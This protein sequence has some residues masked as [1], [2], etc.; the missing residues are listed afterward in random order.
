MKRLFY[1]LMMVCILLTSCSFQE[2]PEEKGLPPVTVSG[3]S[4]HV[5][6]KLKNHMDYAFANSTGI[7]R[8]KMDHGIIQYNRDGQV[9]DEAE[10][11]DVCS[12]SSKP[13]YEPY[14]YYVDD[15]A[16]YFYLWDEDNSWW[17]YRIPFTKNKKGQVVLDYANRE[18]LYDTSNMEAFAVAGNYFVGLT[19]HQVMVTMNIA[20]KRDKKFK[21]LPYLSENCEDWMVLK[22]GEDW[23]LWWG[24]GLVLQKVPSN[25]IIRLETKRNVW[26][27]ATYEMG[28]KDIIC[29][30]IDKCECKSY[31]FDGTSKLVFDKAA[32]KNVIGKMLP[33]KME[34]EKYKID[35][36]VKK[37]EKFYL[38]IKYRKKKEKWTY[39]LLV[40]D[41]TAGKFLCGEERNNC[42][43]PNKLFSSW[44]EMPEG[45]LLSIVEDNW[46]F[47]KGKEAYVYNEEWKTFK[48]IRQG[49]PEWN[50]FYA[51]N[52]NGLEEFV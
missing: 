40:Y 24:D 9:I 38:Q 13:Y 34:I 16:L 12:F 31:R 28:E 33:E 3:G 44:W 30:N 42:L 41:N 8:M 35:N 37:E 6:K 25:E 18:Q 10:A 17:L 50:C 15:K 14:M 49:D 52:D 1:L 51:V 45:S 47:R 23:V 27:D 19:K 48:V 29:F 43:P 26:Y 2:Q 32:V 7:Y 39:A 46:Y 21:K 20:D 36:I 5:Q 22:E 11:S 4:I